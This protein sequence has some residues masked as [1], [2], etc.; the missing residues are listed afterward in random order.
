MKK[1]HD[2][3]MK[4]GDRLHNSISIKKGLKGTAKRVLSD[5]CNTNY[6]LKIEKKERKV[7]RSMIRK[8]VHNDVSFHVAYQNKRFLSQEHGS[9]R[10]TPTG[11]ISHYKCKRSFKPFMVLTF[12][13]LSPKKKTNSKSNLR[14]FKPI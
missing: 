1:I 12:L 6:T 13:A 3:G 8:C 11:A 10:K 4:V 14:S 5:T 2:F 9:L 7:N